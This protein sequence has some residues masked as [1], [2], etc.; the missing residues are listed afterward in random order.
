MQLSLCW[1]TISLLCVSGTVFAD[2][3]I[4]GTVYEKGTAKPLPKVNIFI[5]PEAIKTTTDDAGA[6]RLCECATR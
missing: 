5:L 4:T 1:K 3:R 2:V 6:V